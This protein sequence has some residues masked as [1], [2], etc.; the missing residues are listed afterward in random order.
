[1]ILQLLQDAMFSAIAAIGFASISN[2]PARAFVYCA[3]IAAI[4]HSFRFLEMQALGMHI[5]LAT[6]LASLLIGILAVLFSARSRVPA[7]T[8]LFP[9]LLPMIPGIYAYKA[10]AGLVMC[11]YR[12]GEDTFDHYF[13]LFSSN[14]L[15]CFFILLVMAVGAT[16]PLFMMKRISFTATRR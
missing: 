7:E 15:T 11:V 5:V 2:P 12:S 10:F 16:V 13:Y 9:S 8:Y 3:L 4:G 14:G 6:L 1:M